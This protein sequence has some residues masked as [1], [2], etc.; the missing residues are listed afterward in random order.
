MSLPVRTLGALEVPAVGYGAM[1]LVG[2]YGTPTDDA[3]AQAALT[4]ALDAGCA[5]IDTSDVYGPSER[6]V[7]DLLRGRRRDEVVVS[8]KFGLKPFDGE[9]VHRL[10]VRWAVDDFR[11]NA[12]PRLVRAYCERSL[13]RLGVDHIDLYQPHFTDPEVPIEDTVGAVADLVAAGLVRHV[14]LSNPTVDDLV[15]AQTVTSIAAVQVQ[16]SM[17]FPIEPAL[18]ERCAATGVGVVAY[19]PIGRGFLAG[20]VTRATGADFRTLVQRFQG[21]NLAANNAAYAPVLALAAD[22]GVTPAQLALAWLLDRHPA[23]VPI[24]GSRD[25]GRIRENAAAAT[26]ALSDADRARLDAV[27]ADFAPVGDVS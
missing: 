4:A 7:A 2:T 16:W 3:G 10:P 22:L 17:W 14:A 6:Q 23:V 25:P 15:R 9:P 18:L 1:V 11:I 21:D 24:P 13:R 26:V 8:T 19:A 27:L 20:G 5:L 12:E